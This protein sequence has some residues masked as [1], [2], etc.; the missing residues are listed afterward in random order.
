[1]NPSIPSVFVAGGASWDSIIDLP[2]FPRAQPETFLAAHY[3][4]AV[5]GT[6]A[7]KALNLERLGFNVMLHVVLGQDEWGEKIQ[8]RF[9]RTQIQLLTDIDPKGTERHTNLMDP[10]GRRISIYTHPASPVPGID[11]EHLA[12]AMRH[13]DYVVINTINY[14]R[15]LLPYAQELNKAIWCDL[16]DYDGKDT[17]H[18]DFVAAADYLFMSDDKLSNPKELM[19][20]LI[21]AGKKLV[22]CTHGKLGATALTHDQEWYYIGPHPSVQLTD[23]NGVGDAFF[24][25]YLF[26]H[27]QRL[28]VQQCLQLATFVAFRCIGSSELVDAK[29]TPD[30]ALAEV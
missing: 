29:L 3:H 24:A 27:Q 12:K 22:V 7:G 19:L 28:S 5:G 18:S 25:G 8:Q 15:R 20:S 6:G 21:K 26:A 30:L 11:P 4:E 16:Q 1:M 14:C 17:Y 13:A 23:C 10:E 9:Q 2:Y